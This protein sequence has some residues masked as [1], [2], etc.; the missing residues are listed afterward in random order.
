M[1]KSKFAGLAASRRGKLV[2]LLALALLASAAV[3]TT[4][5][6]L[7]AKT[8][9]VVNSFAAGAVACRVNGD[10]T[11][12]NTAGAVSNPGIITDAYI[13]AAVVVNWTKDGGASVYG[14]PPAATFTPGTGWVQHTDGYYY[15]T[16]VVP[17]GES[18]SALVTALA[19]AD[20]IPDGYA[21]TVQIVAE[22]VQAKGVSGANKAV[23]E[24]WGVD[25]D[26]LA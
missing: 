18:T 25:P 15:Y 13:R 10:H 7:T 3:G 2:L 11:V 21:L 4:M 17:A 22:A 12:T 20:A 6:L 19:C 5:A 14:T 24:A 1:K 23:K 8:E 9:P 16:A 26:A